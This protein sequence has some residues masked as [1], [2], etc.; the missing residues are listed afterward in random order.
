V[1][2]FIAAK[3]ACGVA[4][5]ADLLDMDVSTVTRTLRPLAAAGYVTMR[6]GSRDARRREVRLSS[7]GSR[8]LEKAGTLWV[9]AQ[10]ETL[11]TFGE[12]RHA[13]LLSLLSA[14]R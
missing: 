11:I 9:K 7:K 14:L 10:S 5:L 2:S 1:L 3:P 8:A 13:Q 6:A 12:R 4:E